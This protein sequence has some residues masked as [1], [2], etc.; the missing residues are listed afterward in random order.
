MGV[1]LSLNLSTCIHY[2]CAP[3]HMSIIPSIKWFKEKEKEPHRDMHCQ[4]FLPESRADYWDYCGQLHEGSQ[5][6]DCAI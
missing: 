2:I 6:T 1:H 5:A 4:M 3:F